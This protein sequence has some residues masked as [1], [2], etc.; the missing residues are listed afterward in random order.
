MKNVVRHIELPDLPGDD[1]KKN[2][3]DLWKIRL[4]WFDFPQSI[5]TCITRSDIQDVQIVE[6]SNDAW[7]IDSI[8]T[9][10]K[11]KNGNSEILTCDLDVSQ[12]I[13][14]DGTSSER[15]LQLTIV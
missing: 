11:D 10:V 15:R 3:G 1:F 5:E 13:D 6:G 8:V 9:L 14:G 2:R 4:I 12:W 7:L